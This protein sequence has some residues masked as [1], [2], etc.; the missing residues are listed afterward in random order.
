M[1][2]MAILMAL[3]MVAGTVQATIVF[4]DDFADGIDTANDWNPKWESGSDQQGL[5]QPDGTGSHAILDTSVAIRNYH[6]DTKHAFSVS[7][8]DYATISMD[9]RYVHNGLGNGLQVNKVFIAPQFNYTPTWWDGNPVESKGVVNRNGAIGLTHPLSPWVEGWVAHGS[10]GVNTTAGSSQTSNWIV[11]QSTITVQ[12]GNYWLDT[13]LYAA[14]GT[15]LLLDGTAFDTGNA[16]GGTI[17]AGLTTAWQDNTN[18][19]ATITNIESVH[20]DNFKVE[21]IPEPATLA[22]LGLSSLAFFVRRKLIR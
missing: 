21:V 2:K 9:M 3:A 1:K 11:V 10:L 6:I 12:G 13:D 4:Q 7:G 15:T 22:L 17:Y 16:A 18:S 19:I 20:V 8:T 14:D 5:F